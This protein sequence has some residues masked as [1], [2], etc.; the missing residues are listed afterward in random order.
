MHAQAASEPH[1]A[2]YFATHHHQVRFALGNVQHSRHFVI[3]QEHRCGRKSRF[4]CHGAIVLSEFTA[5]FRLNAGD[6]FGAVALRIRLITQ[7]DPHIRRG[8]RGIKVASVRST[9]QGQS[10]R[11]YRASNIFLSSV[12]SS[13]MFPVMPMDSIQGRMHDSVTYCPLRVR[14][15]KLDDRLR[16]LLRPYF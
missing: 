9:M 10:T 7:N 8:L 5:G 2:G 6:R 11:F 13:G 3:A 12:A 4:C 1:H 14:P 16:I 15:R